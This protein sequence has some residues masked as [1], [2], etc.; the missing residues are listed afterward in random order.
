M[1][2]CQSTKDNM[3]NVLFVEGL[4]FLFFFFYFLNIAPVTLALEGC[5]RLF[6]LSAVKDHR[7]NRAGYQR[8]GCC[9]CL[10]LDK[11]RSNCFVFICRLT[12][13]ELV[14]LRVFQKGCL[15]FIVFFSI[16]IQADRRNHYYFFT[17]PQIRKL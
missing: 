13:N 11:F 14:L 12:N 3:E 2:L 10:L 4:G 16:S 8:K 1:T 6:K 9:V 7:A 17:S 15:R 5:K